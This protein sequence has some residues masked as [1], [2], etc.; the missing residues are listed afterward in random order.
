MASEPVIDLRTFDLCFID[1]EATGHVF[2]HHEIVELALIR[3]TPDGHDEIGRWY[4]KLRP[5]HLE[6]M[7]PKA[8][9]INGYTEE[10]WRGSVESSAEVWRSFAEFGRGAVPV[11]HNPTFDRAHITLAAAAAGVT[12]LGVDYHWI[13]TESLSWPVYKSGSMPKLSLEQL[14]RRFGIEPEP[15][16][17]TAMNGAEVCR[18]V[19]IAIMAEWQSR[20]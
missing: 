13:G 2:G 7:T 14:C 16:P 6:R 10:G 8:R 4:C 9:E 18:A 12:D 11:C 3:T 1:L 17:H 5:K 19:Y 20:R 15:M